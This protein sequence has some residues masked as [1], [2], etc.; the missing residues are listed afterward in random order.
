MRTF[1][2]LP[3][4]LSM[5]LAAGCGGG[6]TPAPVI[7]A[8]SASIQEAVER[9]GDVSIRASVVPTATLDESVARNYGIERSD[10]T[11]LL[12][13]SVR[14][15]PDGA[16]DSIPARVEAKA[17]NLGGQAELI[18]MRELRSGDLL[19]YVGTVSIAPPDTIRFDLRVTPKD[20]ASSTL[21]F[22]REFFPR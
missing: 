11:A 7:G 5:I 4:A 10:S 20:G 22:T 19:D 14:K 2:L 21:Q 12:L 6:S 15:G 13:V 8:S 18:D 9:V 17:S 3:A 16:D 1:R